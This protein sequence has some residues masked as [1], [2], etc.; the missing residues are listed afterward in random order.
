MTEQ[1]RDWF[2]A[3][4]VRERRLILLML[5][6][7]VIL[8]AWL[9]VIRPLGNGYDRALERHLEAVDRNGRVRALAEGA[10]AP[11]Q[12]LAAAPAGVDLGLIVAEAATRSGLTLDSNSPAGPNAV[13][14][15]IA[16]MSAATAVQWLREFELQGISVEDVRMAP[17][18]DGTVSMTARLARSAR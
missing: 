11:R 15:T 6:I 2:F 3:R 9:L 16:Q 1:L 4:S 5:V 18:G 7:A 17:A 14:V 8:L 10:R 13:T 12:A